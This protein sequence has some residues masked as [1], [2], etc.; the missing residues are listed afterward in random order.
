[1]TSYGQGRLRALLVVF[2]TCAILVAGVTLS[3]E[4]LRWRAGVVVLQGTGR[5]EGIG[6]VDLL[7]MLKP[8]SPF[9][10]KELL[11]TP[12]A[13]AV[14]SNPYAFAADR[15]RGAHLF[16]THC[17]AC[18]GADG[19][20]QSAPSLVGRTLKFGDADWSLFQTVT[21]GRPDVAMPPASVS[22]AEAWQIVGHV[23][24]LR[25]GWTALAGGD[26]HGA[27]VRPIDLSAERI[28]RADFEPQNWLTYSG[29]YSSWR[30]SQLDEI[31]TENVGALK[32]AWS[33]QLDSSEPYIEATPLVVDGV[34]FL[35]TPGSDVIAADAA[36]G[37]VLWRYA[38]STPANVPTC[39]G[40]NNRGV[41]VLG[42]RV[43]V[44]TL[45]NRV[46]ALDSSTGAVAWE[47][48]VA[49]YR[50]GYSMTGAPLAVGDKIIVGVAGSE[51]GIRGFLDAYDA[52]TGERAWRFDTIPVPGTPGSE[53]WENDAWKTGGGSTWVTG[54]FDPALGLVYWG[55][56]NPAPDFNRDVRPGDN[57]YTASV[58]AL[59]AD[60]GKLRWHFQFT[61]HDEHDWD[62]N[63]VPVLVDHDVAGEPRHLML[64]GNRNGFYYVLDRVTG[65]PSPLGTLTWPGLSGGGNWWSP[66]YSPANDLVYIPFAESPKVFFKNANF[67]NAEPIPGIQFLGSASMATG[68]PLQAG[69]RALDPI[70]G[71]VK[72]EYLRLRP[73]SNV[74]WIGGVLSTAGNLAFVGDLRDFVAFDAA[75]GSELWRLNLGG[76]INAAPISY[77]VEGSQHVAIMA[78]NALYVF[79][80]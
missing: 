56:G 59:D 24:S 20:G 61:P 43:F 47:I 78:G 3:V 69:I 53:T 73:Q 23:R 36:T 49:D 46:I 51:F 17:A 28:E 35:T 67:E 60:T 31:T 74:G 79:R 58:V 12:N 57:L 2:A 8:G 18:H 40:R 15:E 21:R 44:A 9:Y 71:A 33:L 4:G 38:S 77:S 14:I 66:S 70:T 50:A 45:D 16:Q 30:H 13:Y 54:S 41:A 5:L 37:E 7:S 32:L 80:L 22:D 25:N 29:S 52:A 76:Y 19:S 75:E 48:A 63:Q 68:E 11:N 34:M 64:W 26:S 42:D 65:E 6:W 1:M 27:D 10:L 72:W 55:V 62:A 39:C